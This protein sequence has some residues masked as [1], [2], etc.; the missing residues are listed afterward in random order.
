MLL[1]EAW[2]NLYRNPPPRPEA[3]GPGAWAWPLVG[4]PRGR[5]HWWECLGG[6]AASRSCA[7]PDANSSAGARAR[8]QGGRDG[9]TSRRDPGESSG[10]SAGVGD[11]AAPR[12]GR[13]NHGRVVVPAAGARGARVT[14]E[15]SVSP[16]VRGGR[17]RGHRGPSSFP[18][19]L[20]QPRRC[21]KL[22]AESNELVAF[23]ALAVG[24]LQRGGW[25][26]GGLPAQPPEPSAGYF[27]GFCKF[28]LRFL[29]PRKA[30]WRRSHAS[31]M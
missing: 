7:G 6:V 1:G 18:G 23:V 4:V 8:C 22:V 12:V 29:Q 13:E 17:R 31:F 19:R 2:P 25:G 26:P 14:A 20:L 15:V 11:A 9:V 10:A 5:D 21:T 30:E 27:S 28:V 3:G 16:G 24:A